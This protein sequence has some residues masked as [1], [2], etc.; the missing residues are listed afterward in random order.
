MTGIRNN[1]LL[2]VNDISDEKQIYTEKN[3][4]RNI[5]RAFGQWQ[6]IGMHRWLC[7]D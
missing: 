2:Q 5:N 1:Q 4:D 3:N 7:R 6:R